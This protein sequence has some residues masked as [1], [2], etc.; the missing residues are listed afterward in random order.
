VIKTDKN[1]IEQTEVLIYS[2]GSEIHFIA[3]FV[4]HHG[5]IT[6]SHYQTDELIFTKEFDNSN[7]E[8]ITLNRNVSKVKVNI[9]SDEIN[10]SKIVTL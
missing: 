6:V 7:H 8:K 9:I 10:F 2:I 5:N 1:S 3:L 4:L